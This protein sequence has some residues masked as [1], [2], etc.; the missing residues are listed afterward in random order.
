M[1]LKQSLNNEK[2]R[3]MVKASWSISWPMTFIMFFMFVVGFTDVYVAGRMGKEVQAAYGLASQLYFVFSIVVFALTV[4]SVSVISRLFT[5]ENKTEFYTAVD[6]SLI[7]AG[8]AGTFFSLL[9]IF[10]AGVI[11]NSLTIPEA[12]KGYTIPLLRIYSAGLLF[13]YLLINT[14]GI[15]RACGMIKKSLWT[16]AVVC[17][18][19][20][21]L[22][23]FLAFKTSLQFKGIAVATVIS[24]LVGSVL[25]L[26]FMRKLT[27]G[28]FHFSFATVKKVFG[29]GWP[30][31]FQQILWQSGIVVIFL[32]LSALPRNNIEV[33]AAFT[34]GLKIE[35]AIFLPAFAFNLANAVIIGN[36]IGKREKERAFSSGVVTAGM[37][38]FIVL[39]L[40]VVVMVNVRSISGILSN[41]EVVVRETITYILIM[42]IAEPVMSWGVILAGGLYG[43]GDTRSVMRITLFS[44]WLVRIPV[45]YLFGVRLGMGAVSV[46]WAMNLSI[47]AQ[48]LLISR[49]YFGRRWLDNPEFTPL[50]Q[51]PG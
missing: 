24:M 19:N 26:I 30:A 49:R 18:A 17:L 40:C 11:I 47:L 41:N 23:F 44:I 12:L 8:I 13:S 31:G 48:C 21:V 42:L 28:L 29:I 9:G 46:W 1:N 35:S 51:S 39:V 5:S 36:L 10:F 32:I 15:L 43:A 38:V 6:S 33:M 3:A 45:S 34:N 20:V 4:G 14:N 27:N 22:I 50:E 2:T 7:I 25:N 16:M 37:G